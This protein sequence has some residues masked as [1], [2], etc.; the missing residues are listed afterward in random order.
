MSYT[1]I[2]FLACLNV[3]STSISEAN[4]LLCTSPLSMRMSITLI[5]TVSSELTPKLT[6]DII[7]TLVHRARVSLPDVMTETI[8]IVL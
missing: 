4:K 3:F 7:A 2:M 8:G 6:C 1:S 5:A